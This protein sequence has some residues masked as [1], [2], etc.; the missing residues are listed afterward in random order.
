MRRGSV[1]SHKSGATSHKSGVSEMLLSRGWGIGLRLGSRLWLGAAA[2]GGLRS[3]GIG[4]AYT[5]LN[6]MRCQVSLVLVDEHTRVQESHMR[7]R[8]ISSPLFVSTGALVRRR[9]DQRF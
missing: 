3:P 6:A 1:T 8:K 5:L 9:K 7:A 4:D 2:S